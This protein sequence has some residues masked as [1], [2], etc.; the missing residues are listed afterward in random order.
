M[1]STLQHQQ[2]SFSESNVIPNHHLGNNNELNR[3]TGRLNTVEPILPV[4]K[5]HS[6]N[7]ENEMSTSQ[8]TSW[9]LSEYSSTKLRQNSGESTIQNSSKDNVL[10]FSQDRIYLPGVV[11]KPEPNNFQPMVNVRDTESSVRRIPEFQSTAV[12]TDWKLSGVGDYVC[13]SLSVSERDISAIKFEI[14][15]LEKTNLLL[16]NENMELQN[17]KLRLEILRHQSG[18]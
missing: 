10:D 12:Q 1:N 7:I 4:Q 6:V 3:P 14:L 15:N 13:P 16:K 9:P 5:H 18:L 2:L 17:A 8:I 11:I